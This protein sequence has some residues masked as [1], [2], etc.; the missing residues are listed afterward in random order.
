MK[1]NT[2]NKLINYYRWLEKNKLSICDGMTENIT[3][4]NYLY[5]L[6]LY[7]GFAIFLIINRYREEIISFMRSKK[8]G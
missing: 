7:S 2:P 4:F 8:H 6:F 5:P 1:L 3:A